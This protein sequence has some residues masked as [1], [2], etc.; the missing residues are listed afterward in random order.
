[1]P[2]TQGGAVLII[3]RRLQESSLAAFDDILNDGTLGIM[4]MK[5][6]ALVEEYPER[7]VRELLEIGV[8]N[9]V[10]RN[11]DRNLI[12]PRITLLA[13]EAIII[14]QH[15][16]KC[17][18]TGKTVMTHSPAPPGWMERRRSI[19]QSSPGVKKYIRNRI[20]V[21]SKSHPGTF[22]TVVEWTDGTVSCSCN[23]IYHRPAEYRCH[24]ALGLIS[25]ITGR[26]MTSA[27]EALKQ[28]EKGVSA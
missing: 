25:A 4:T 6:L 24:H 2:N 5:A 7:T 13:E 17:T 18:I 9:G 19:S 12:A 1:M 16:R 15:R 23:D 26:D 28:E 3:Q 8:I 10:Y 22:H 21:E 27:Y 20:E 14:R 11:A